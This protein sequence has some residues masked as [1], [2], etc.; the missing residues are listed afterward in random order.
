V[1]AS[2][3]VNIP[4]GPDVAGN[5]VGNGVTVTGG[6]KVGGSVWS[7]ADLT[8]SGGPRI[9]GNVTAA[10]MNI[11]G[12]IS[13]NAWIYGLSQLDWGTTLSGNLMTKTLSVP[14][15]SNLI[16]GTTTVTNPSTPGTSPYA[17]PTRP[18]VANWVD[19]AYNAS[20]W[21][22]FA[23]VVLVSPTDCSYTALKA[24]VVALGS[25][26]GLIDARAC[27][28]ITIGGA[29]I[30]TLGSDVAIVANKFDFGGGGGFTS[31]NSRRL[32][33]INPDTTAN[34]LPTCASGESFS[35]SGG[36]TFNANLSVMM[37]SPCAVAI[38]SSTTFRG[39]VFSGAAS[40]N[41]G[42]TIGYVP[43]GLPGVN[44]DTG[45][46]TVPSGTEAN[47]TIVS[48]RNVQVGN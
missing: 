6:S 27:S 40:I 38:G 14:Q 34:S 11:Q 17:T 5:V 31:S 43:V 9:Y 29:D 32:W 23:E 3:R 46:S 44:L 16:S 8:M 25:Q 41:G 24:K 45:T 22:G 47:R 37:Y 10:S 12:T 15:Y 30:I 13:G 35:V 28:S 20:Q 26:S 4:G 21:P 7:T 18:V 48:S 33:L 19:F 2:G 1:W 36:F 42:S 39:Q